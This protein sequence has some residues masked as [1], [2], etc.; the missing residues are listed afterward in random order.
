MRL[1]W[2]ELRSCI[3]CQRRFHIFIVCWLC[4]NAKWSQMGVLTKNSNEGGWTSRTFLTE[5]LCSEIADRDT[6]MFDLVKKKRKKDALTIYLPMY[7][8][9]ERQSMKEEK[10]AW[11]LFHLCYKGYQ[12]LLWQ[13]THVD[14]SI[15]FPVWLLYFSNTVHLQISFAMDPSG[16]QVTKHYLRQSPSIRASIHHFTHFSDSVTGLS[17]SKGNKP[18]HHR[19]PHTAFTL[20]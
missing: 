18:L 16:T 11:I 6:R 2:P 14:F 10:W 8:R 5:Q 17:W 12:C 7:L 1:T 4:D 19:A 3:M 20:I 15:S 13:Y 9:R